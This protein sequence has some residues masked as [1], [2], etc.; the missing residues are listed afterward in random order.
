MALTEPF[1]LLPGF[2][3]WT[4]GFALQWRQEQSV[5]ASGRILVKDMGA[6]LWSLRAA[7][8]ALKPNALDYWRARLDAL[9]NGLMTFW[10]YSMSRCYPQ[11]YP[12]G[13]WPTGSSFSGTT[14]VLASISTD[15]KT[16][17][18]SALPAGFN[19]KVGDYIAVIVATSPARRDLH[20]VMEVAT[21]SGGGVTGAFEVR[22]HIWPDVTTGKNVSV[23]QPACLMAIVPGSVASDAQLNGFG[24]VSF[25]AIEARL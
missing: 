13:S 22:P 24:T 8:T 9:E 6:P 18:L 2:P 17:T 25:Q 16:V 20:Q 23:K 12:Y 14:A 1:D 7:S 21:A 15:R 4:I 19:L 5:Q 3:G 10:G 11:A